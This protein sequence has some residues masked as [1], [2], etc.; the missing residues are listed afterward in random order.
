M[1]TRALRKI[2]G[3]CLPFVLIALGGCYTVL[4]TSPDSS[5]SGDNGLSSD[6]SE[7]DFTSEISYN[8]NCL[9]CH[10]QAELDDRYYDMQ[11]AGIVNAHGITIDPYGWRAPSA[12]IPWWYEVIAPVPAQAVA[13]TSPAA[14]SAGPRIRNS[15]DSRGTD[16]SGTLPPTAPPSASA[17]AA[18]GATGVVRDRPAS[19]SAAPAPERTRSSTTTQ[20]APR[21]S[22][23]GRGDD[24]P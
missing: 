2:T 16:A 23:S 3:L 15:G 17:P 24:K 7:G 9:S 1:K 5:Q 6:S 21:K 4:M 22:G 18:S 14:G 12:S 11:N 8:Q 10:S 20:P 13:T 19:T